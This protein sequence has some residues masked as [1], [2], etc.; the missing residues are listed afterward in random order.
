MSDLI[1]AIVSVVVGVA[2]TLLVGHYYFRRT[3]NKALTPFVHFTTSLFRGVS[4]EVREELQI[5]YRGVRVTEVQELQFLIANTGDRAIRDVIEPLTVAIPPT[6]SLLNAAV[7]HVSP[8]ERVVEV[9]PEVVRVRVK[10]PLLNSGE[11]F[12]LR[13]LLN[14]EATAKDFQFRITAD[15]LPPVLATQR[16]EPDLVTS[17]EKRRFEPALFF[18]SVMF[19]IFAMA[20]ATVVY[21]QWATAVFPRSGFWSWI[22]A[23]SWDTALLIAAAIPPLLLIV[24]SVMLFFGSFANFSFPPRRRFILPTDLLR[25]PPLVLHDQSAVR[26]PQIPIEA[27]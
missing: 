4:P 3:V 14:G 15:D 9:I 18:T 11:F 26:S 20:L 7:L 25:R 8:S 22:P 27:P 2:V 21:R 23:S 13:L 6:C 12:V 5:H 16:L 17:S 1:I 19:G 24:L 10:F